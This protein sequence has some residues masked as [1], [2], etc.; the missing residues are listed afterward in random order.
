[1]SAVLLPAQRAQHRLTFREAM[2]EELA[3]DAQQVG[4]E[5]AA[6]RVIGQRAVLARA[7]EVTGAQR[8]EVLRDRGLIELQGVP[9]LLHGQLPRREQLENADARRMTERAKEIG[10][11]RLELR[12]RHYIKIFEYI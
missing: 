11:E 6:Q 9:E 10:L 8:S 7:D 2:A 1:M 3:G 12:W 4:D 5:A